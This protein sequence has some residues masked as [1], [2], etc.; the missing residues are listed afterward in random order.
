V[1]FPSLAGRWRVGAL[2][3]VVL[4]LTV[5][6]PG[7][8]DQENMDARWVMVAP[9]AGVVLAVIITCRSGWRGVQSARATVPVVA[10]LGLMSLPWV[11][12]EAGF[13]LPGGVFLTDELVTEPGESGLWPAVHLGDH[14]GLSAA[15]LIVTA[16]LLWSG[17]R[18]EP[19]TPSRRLTQ[20]YLALLLSYGVV[21]LA[22]DFWGEQIAARGWTGWYIP[23]ALEP[24]FSAV[25]LVVL[26]G[27]VVAFFLPASGRPEEL[28]ASRGGPPKGPAGTAAMRVTRT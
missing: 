5:A 21:N 9:A 23:D 19:R 2:L 22:Q 8:L 4:C 1:T 17:P 6:V 12:A 16:L 13:S 27:A 10:V 7:V 20:G 25:W 14:H 15:L 3:A 24:G 28:R 11:A 26:A 18:G